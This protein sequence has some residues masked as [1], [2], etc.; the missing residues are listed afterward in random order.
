MHLLASSSDNYILASF[1]LEC[2]FGTVSWQ[3]MSAVLQC[4]GC[5]PN[6]ISWVQ[7]LYMDPKASMC[8]GG[9]ISDYWALER[10]TW[11]G[12]PL[13]PMLFAHAVQPLA[14]RLIASLR[15]WGSKL[16]I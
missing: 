5:D 11:Q 4:M 2:A 1:D 13:S 9:I 7:L 15:P 8:M 6:Y 10:G 12:Y 14:C 3:Y 16:V